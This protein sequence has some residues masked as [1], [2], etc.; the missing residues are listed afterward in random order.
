MCARNCFC[1]LP[2]FVDIQLAPVS[3]TYRLCVLAGGFPAVVSPPLWC[4]PP[5]CLGAVPPPVFRPRF[6]Y[7][8]A[9]TCRALLGPRHARLG[10]A[11]HGGAHRHH[12]VRVN[13][14]P[15]RP[16]G[17]QQAGCVWSWRGRVS[18]HPDQ[19]MTSWPFRRIQNRTEGGF[20]VI[21]PV[22]S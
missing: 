2:I 12:P 19:P 17:H 9:P 5:R 13:P 18:T 22:N 16:P 11:A 6:L 15:G 14:A 8:H 3:N 4:F 10:L 7:D 20:R 21:T 1:W